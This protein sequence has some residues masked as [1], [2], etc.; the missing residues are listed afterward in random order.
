MSVLRDIDGFV[1][2]LVEEFE[3]HVRSW[4]VDDGGREELVDGFVVLWG[5]RVVDEAG[6]AD[7]GRG[8]GEKCH[9]NGFGVC[10]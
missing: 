8:G 3:S 4:G 1:D 2:P 5:G 9:A 10:D 7:R 6:A